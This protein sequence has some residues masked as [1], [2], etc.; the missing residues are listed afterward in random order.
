VTEAAPPEVEHRDEALGR[1]QGGVS[2]KI[3]LRVDRRGKIIT[4][5]VSAG[6]RHEQSQFC[7][8]MEQGAVKRPGRGRPRLR[9]ARVAGDKGYSSGMIRRY[10]RRRGIGVVIPTKKNERADPRFDRAAYRERNV[11]E[12]TINRLKQFRRIATRYEKRA[13]YYLGM[14]TLGAILLWL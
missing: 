6:Q 7:A 14:L 8:L 11:V 9:P 13:I 10:L 12:R 1:S 3:H 5:L 2:T 4:F